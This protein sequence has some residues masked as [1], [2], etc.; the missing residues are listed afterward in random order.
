VSIELVV[1]DWN[2]TLSNA[3]DVPVG[4]TIPPLYDGVLEVLAALDKQHCH[5]AIATGHSFAGLSREV[6]DT[7]NDMRFAV[8]SGVKAVAV[9]YGAYPASG[10]NEYAPHAMIDDIRELLSVVNA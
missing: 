3:R 9:S 4:N 6:G 5:M 8:N 7:A 10:L 1:F 2:G